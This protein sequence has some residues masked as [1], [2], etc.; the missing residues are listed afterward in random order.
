MVACKVKKKGGGTTTYRIAVS[1]VSEQRRLI[2]T[3]RS[4]E[5]RLKAMIDS[6]RD[7]AIYTFTSEGQIDSWSAG[8]EQLY[9][10]TAAE[11]MGHSWDILFSP[12]ARSRGIPANRLRQ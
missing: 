3:L 2:N 6:A 7:Y 9:G 12:E 8:A 4:T 10:Y 1:D 5:Q 11:I